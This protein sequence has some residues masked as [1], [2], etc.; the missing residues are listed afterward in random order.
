[1]LSSYSA[2]VSAKIIRRRMAMLIGEW[3]G[4]KCSET[5][6]PK[7]YKILLDLLTPLDTRND[8]VVRMSTATALRDAVDEWHFK[9]DDFLP[10]LDTF[11]I[12]TPAEH[13]KG[14]VIGLISLVQQIESGM[15][16]IRV[17]EVIVER[18]DRKVR[19]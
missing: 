8:I 13:D 17:I 1:M 14:G 16:L 7:V 18:M 15:K 4:T 10:Y 9:A 5:S 12:G 2:N 19:L 11:L 3:V 6:R